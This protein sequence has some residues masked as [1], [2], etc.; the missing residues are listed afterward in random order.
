MTCGMP[1]DSQSQSPRPSGDSDDHKHGLSL[2][3]LVGPSPPDPSRQFLK[4]PPKIYLQSGVRQPNP[5]LKLLCV[6]SL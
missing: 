3:L 1:Y 2:S 5:H 4:T 6:A